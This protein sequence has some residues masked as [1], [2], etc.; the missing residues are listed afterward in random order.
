MTDEK[1][2][3]AHPLFLHLPFEEGLARLGKQA[4]MRLWSL[5][6][7]QRE[8]EKRPGE[9]GALPHQ[10]VI[11]SGLPLEGS[12]AASSRTS[13]FYSAGS[14]RVRAPRAQ[15]GRACTRRRGPWQALSSQARTP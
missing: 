4:L 14:A 13:A 3:Q 9:P 7:A 1:Q 11:K 12:R 6:T 5:R 8:N 10:A 15:S 2:K